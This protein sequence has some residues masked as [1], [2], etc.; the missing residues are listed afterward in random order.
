M[1][2]DGFA[3]PWVCAGGLAVVVVAAVVAAAVVA[4]AV[5]VVLEVVVLAAVVVF[6]VVLVGA[7][8]L[9]ETAVPGESLPPPQ[10]AR[11]SNTAALIWSLLLV[12]VMI[13]LPVIGYRTSGRWVV[14][15]GRL[16]DKATSVMS[17]FIF[18][19]RWPVQQHFFMFFCCVLSTIR[20]R[21]C[22]VQSLY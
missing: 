9:A 5:V 19:S 15:T 17:C 8:G 10:P 16:C 3:P 2:D 7:A 14:T 1:L 18:L 4:A 12:T 20:T 22:A 21:E 6:A 11:R 13:R